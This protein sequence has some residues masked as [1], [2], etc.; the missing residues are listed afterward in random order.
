MPDEWSDLE[1]LF[2]DLQ[3]VNGETAHYNVFLPF[4]IKASLD[5]PLLYEKRHR[6]D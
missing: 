4:Q 5:K 1:S 3:S 6:W 2:H